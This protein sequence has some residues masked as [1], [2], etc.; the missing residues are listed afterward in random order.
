MT[1]CISLSEE[2]DSYKRIQSPIRVA[3]VLNRSNNTAIYPFNNI[4]INPTIRSARMLTGDALQ[5]LT[6][7]KLQNYLSSNKTVDILLYFSTYFKNQTGTANT[8]SE[9]V[10]VL[11]TTDRILDTTTSSNPDGILSSIPTKD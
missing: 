1:L 11:N 10:G 8:K 2:D 5:Y 9:A 7:L 4:S 3:I 6:L